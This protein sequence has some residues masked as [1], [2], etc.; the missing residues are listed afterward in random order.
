MT[1]Q[2][3]LINI[4]RKYPGIKGYVLDRMIKWNRGIVYATLNNLNKKGLVARLAED[5]EFRYYPVE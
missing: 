3:A 4:I 5:G 2:E 1:K